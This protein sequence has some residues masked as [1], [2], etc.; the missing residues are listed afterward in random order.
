MT[1][2]FDA[3]VKIFQLDEKSNP[4][5][6]SVQFKKFPIYGCHFLTA[7]TQILLTSRR[8]YFYTFDLLSGTPQKISPKGFDQKSLERAFPSPMGRW[9]AFTGKNGYIFLYDAKNF[10]RAAS[11]KI[12][13]DGVSSIAFSKDDRYLFAVGT[14]HEIYQ[15]DLTTFKCLARV[16]DQAGLQG[17][18]LA[19]SGSGL[20]LG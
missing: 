5:L 8:S 20:A 18:S 15:F 19:V 7:S 13:G 11:L 14:D 3:T 9:V 6:Q 4:L 2:G 16:V 10:I 12:N 1:G 17:T